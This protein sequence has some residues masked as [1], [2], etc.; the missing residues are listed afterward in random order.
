MNE[1]RV[2]KALMLCGVVALSRVA[3]CA[4][5]EVELRGV[6]VDAASDEPLAGR[7]YIRSLN[8]GKFYLAE[9]AVEGEDQPPA[10][11]YDVTRTESSETHTALP[12]GPFVAKLPMGGYELT[13]ERG[14]QYR[15]AKIKVQVGADGLEAKVKL[16][17]WIDFTSRGWYSGDTHV[18]RPLKELPA[19]M[20]ADDLNVALPLT[21]WVRDAMQSPA[22]AGVQDETADL[23]PE[24]LA[25][26]IEVDP[27]HVIY[28]MNTEYEIFRIKEQAHTLG[29]L[30]VLNHRTPLQDGVPPIGPAVAQA[31]SEGALLELD[32]HNWPWSMAIAAAGKV[33]LYELTNNHIW[34][35]KF[36]FHDFGVQPPEYMHIEKHPDGGVTEN[37]WVDYTMQN[38]YALVN[39]GL[40]MRPT[41]GTA[42]GVHPVPLGYGRVFVWLPDGFSYKAW[43]DGLRKG[44]SF[45]TTGPLLEMNLNEEA[46]GATLQ[47]ISGVRQRLHGRVFSLQ[48]LSKLEVIQDGQVVASLPTPNRPREDGGFYNDYEYEVRVEDSTWVCVRCFE[49]TEDG[50]RRFAHGSPIFLDVPNRPLQPRA[51]ELEFLKGRVTDEL[52]RSRDLT[53]ARSHR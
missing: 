15:P 29:A 22:A 17:R 6:I 23:P 47:V 32:K 45:V 10:A 4:A 26:L 50:R 20:L 27:T 46:P 3:P 24:Q 49:P 5:Q 7:L 25:K 31:R 43:I 8:D 44:R 14:K 36:V 52:Q 9:S 16:A 48:P 53:L 18:H 19:A 41:G 38:Y 1:S 40:R 30:F 12:A 2:L 37:G 21:Y 39:S 33:D 28:P 11:P 35:S 34:R 13:V 51:E 42:S